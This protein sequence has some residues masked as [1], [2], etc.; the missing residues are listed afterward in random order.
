MDARHHRRDLTHDR[1]E[2]LIEICVEGLDGLVAAQ[3]A[4]ADRVELCASLLEGGITP[5]I[6]TVR[7][8][9]GSP[10]FPFF[11]MV[12]PR[13]GDFLYSDLEY[14]SMLE[15]VAAFR[16][17]GVPGVVFGCLTPEGRIDV[18]THDGTDRGSAPHGCHLSSCFRYDARRTEAIEDLVRCGVDRVLTSGHRETALEGLDRL[19]DIVKAAAGRISVMAC[20]GLDAGN[21]ATVRDRVDPPELHFAALTTRPG[22]MVF[23]NLQIGMGA[24]DKDREYS[25]TLT[26]PVIVAATIA[27]ARHYLRIALRPN[28][29]MIQK[30]PVH[31]QDRDKRRLRTTARG[32]RPPLRTRPSPPRVEPLRGPGRGT[33][34]LGR[35][36]RLGAMRAV[37]NLLPVRGLAA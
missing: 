37:M 19:T 32:W 28:R 25:L 23:R 31:D 20:G 8:A 22:G 34:S 12:R 35:R 10:A 21:I 16:S 6:G 36:R 27:A 7:A 24:A 13:G 17:L 26:D 15:D 30:R 3:D 9:L 14:R 5:S 33:G 4:G 2:R 29:D 18:A 1:K 11:V